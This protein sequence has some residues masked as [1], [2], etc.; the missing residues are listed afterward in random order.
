MSVPRCARWPPERG[1]GLDGDGDRGEQEVAGEVAGGRDGD[2]EQLARRTLAVGA[3]DQRDHRRPTTPP[4]TIPTP[5][6]NTL[7][8][9]PL[10]GG[11]LGDQHAERPDQ[12]GV[13]RL[14]RA[15]QEH[16]DGRVEAD[17]DAALAAVEDHRELRDDHDQRDAEQ[18]HP[19]HVG[20]V[21]DD[22]GRRPGDQQH[23]R[24]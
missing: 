4:P 19:G 17:L 18:L 20:A 5:T 16:Q 22:A 11:D 9:R 8:D 21:P 10:V 1:R 13:V 15:Q 12:Q 7:T 14:E 23:A 24:R 3:A 2:G 6:L